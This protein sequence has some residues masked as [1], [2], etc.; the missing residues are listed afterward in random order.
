M[1]QKEQ[2]E[3]E[4]CQYLREAIDQSCEA[5][6]HTYSKFYCQYLTAVYTHNC[7]FTPR[8]FIESFLKPS[9]VP[10]SKHPDTLR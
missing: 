9:F 4:R 3:M 1:D 5:S 10:E 6:A 7:G 8:S 2:K